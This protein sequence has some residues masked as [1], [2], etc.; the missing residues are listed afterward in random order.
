MSPLWE[1][2]DRAFI[3]ANHP[4]TTEEYKR[5]VETEFRNE[6][7]LRSLPLDEVAWEM[8]RTIHGWM[9]LHWSER[10]PYNPWE[11]SVANDWLGAPFSSHV[12]D[13]FWK[14]HGFIDETITLW[15]SANQ[16][17]AGFSSAWDGHSGYLPE[18]KHTANPKL[19]KK[20]DVKHKTLKI[21]T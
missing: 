20:L 1:G 15:E 6:D 3:W 17:K 4:N 8:E 12:N 10:I 21:M 18:M 9:H 13:A 2:A 14:L 7:W 19:L 11:E 16:K 5:M